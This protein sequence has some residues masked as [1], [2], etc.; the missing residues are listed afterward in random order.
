M[1]FIND[2]GNGEISASSI[3]GLLALTWS[4][5]AL[6]SLSSLVW[7]GV[8]LLSVVLENGVVLH[9]DVGGGGQCKF[10][11]GC[12]NTYRNPLILQNIVEYKGID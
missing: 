8:G 1:G 3:G 9:A 10:E 11:R 6:S 7:S 12:V 5:F 2:A 4:A